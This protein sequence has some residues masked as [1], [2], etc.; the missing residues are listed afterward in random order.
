VTFRLALLPE[1]ADLADDPSGIAM[2]VPVSNPAS[3]EDEIYRLALGMLWHPAEAERARRDILS[4]KATSDPAPGE[5]DP[6]ASRLRLA[7][8]AL[9][10]REPSDFERQQWTFE[11]LAE[12][13]ARGW[14]E[15]L[16]ANAFGP[17]AHALVDEVRLS[18]WLTVLLCLDRPHRIAF[19]VSQLDDLDA[20]TAATILGLGV[21]E[22]RVRAGHAE[23]RI[24]RF[25]D[26][27]CGVVN[28]ENP[29][30]CTRRLGRAL[31]TGR[32]D[33]DEL[34]FARSGSPG[35]PTA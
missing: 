12:D 3:V 22:F 28:G 34:L 30:H 25:L 19:L 15:P 11:T 2:R 18:C 8:R 4:D 6:R 32:V 23:E 10:E 21:E 1:S 33:P 27:H 26:A 35:A 13:L 24:R 5:F 16:P 31:V 9:L 17:N 7:V 29:C 20:P 14:D